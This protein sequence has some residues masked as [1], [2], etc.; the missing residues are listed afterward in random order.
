MK[1]EQQEKPK[2]AVTLPKY[3]IKIILP[4]N[5]SKRHEGSEDS[6]YTF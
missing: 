6:S 5:I 4:D 1:K 2:V 3:K